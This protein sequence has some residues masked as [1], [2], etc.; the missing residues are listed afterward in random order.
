MEFSD[1]IKQPQQ[2]NALRFTASAAYWCVVLPDIS[3]QSI[4]RLRVAF[5]RSS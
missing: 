4:Y 1:I 3:K 5:A 2:E